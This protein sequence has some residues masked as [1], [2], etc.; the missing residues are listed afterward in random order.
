MSWTCSWTWWTLRCETM[1]PSFN[2]R[3]K[4]TCGKL[5][6]ANS[7]DTQ[8]PWMTCEKCYNAGYVF[9]ELRYM[10]VKELCPSTLLPGQL[11]S[12]LG[13]PGSHTLG[14]A[15]SSWPD[16]RQPNSTLMVLASSG[17]SVPAGAQCYP[18]QATAHALPSRY[19]FISS[20]A[21]DVKVIS[22]VPLKP[23]TGLTVG[24]P[25]SFHLTWCLTLS[26]VAFWLGLAARGCIDGALSGPPCE[27]WSVSRQR[28]YENHEGPRPLRSSTSLW[29]LACLW[30]K[31]ALQVETANDL[32]HFCALLHFI[33][34]A[35]G[36][37]SVME[38]PDLPDP[39][40]HPTA[41]SI[42]KL[43]AM[44]LLGSLQGCSLEHVHQGLFGALSPK[45]TGLLC[46]HLPSPLVEFGRE[47]QTRSSLPRALKMGL[48]TSGVYNTFQL[49]EYPPAFN[50][51]LAG[52]FRWWFVHTDIHVPH[53]FS[54]SEVDI[55]KRF[56]THLGQG[57]AG[58]DFANQNS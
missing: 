7:A 40:E 15:R 56:E 19:L 55:L 26:M 31:E 30:L 47:Y 1:P 22:S 29:G 58:P 53:T 46:A 2:L 57:K 44:E 17:P 25:S 10:I 39:V 49:K 48:T 21:G 13:S 43:R 41:P 45:P 52:A 36:K 34:W 20:A 51:M 27:S 35:Q 32:L 3:P 4:K 50:D 37:F 54:P 18:I 8:S 6:V 12:N 11:L 5:F 33:L 38:R 24:L 14:C 28:W 23:S 9:C 42:W 16:I